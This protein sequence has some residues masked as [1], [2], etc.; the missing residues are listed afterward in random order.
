MNA[1]RFYL[2]VLFVV[3]ILFS[4]GSDDD[5]GLT[6]SVGI[7]KIEVTQTGD[8]EDFVIITTVAGGDGIKGNLFNE[9]GKDLGLAYNLSDTE[10]KKSKYMFYT[11]KEGITL[12]Y[13]ITA[14]LTSD[15]QKAMK[16]NVIGYFN[17][18][19]IVEKSHEFKSTVGVANPEVFQ[20]TL[21]DY[22]Q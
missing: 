21:S 1:L 14:N 10:R 15:E 20:I 17:D 4:C 18:K 22:N 8:I 16:V 3:P 5:K 9:D 6:S 12:I 2:F 7:Y 19:K 11:S 13:T